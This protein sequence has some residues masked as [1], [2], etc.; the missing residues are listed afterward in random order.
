MVNLAGQI[1]HWKPFPSPCSD[2]LCDFR[3][4]L[5]LNKGN[6]LKGII[7]WLVA[8]QL[9]VQSPVMALENNVSNTF[10]LFQ[11]LQIMLAIYR[12]NHIPPRTPRISRLKSQ[13][14][15]PTFLS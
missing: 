1:V 9:V 15:K 4:Y 3:E 7:I 8:A 14:L 10:S 11:L 6:L 13:I 5:D 2:S 12:F